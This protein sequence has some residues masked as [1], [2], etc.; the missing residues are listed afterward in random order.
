MSQREIAEG[1]IAKAST[2]DPDTRKAEYLEAL[3]KAQE[4]DNYFAEPYMLL[5]FFYFKEQNWNE[6]I[7]N[8]TKCLDIDYRLSG[9]EEKAKKIYLTLGKSH[10]TVGNKEQSLQC[11]KNFIAHFPES[12]LTEK[13][14]K[15]IFVKLKD[16]EAWYESYKKGYRAFQE[17]KYKDAEHLFTEAITLNPSFFWAYYYHGMA[18]MSLSM[19]PESLNLAL[20]DL[21]KAYDMN[22]H[23]LI[24]LQLYRV[25]NELGNEDKAMF[26]IEETLE[27]NP[28]YAPAYLEMGK[29]L[30]EKN[31]VVS[32]RENL[33]IARAI[34]PR[35]EIAKE[36]KKLLEAP[37]KLP[38]PPPMPTI[39]SPAVEAKPLPPQEAPPPVEEEAAEPQATSASVGLPE[40]EA[41]GDDDDQVEDARQKAELILDKAKTRAQGFLDKTKE[42]LK[43]LRESVDKERQIAR[44]DKKKLADE[45]EEIVKNAQQQADEIEAKAKQVAQDIVE[46]ARTQAREESA[47]MLKDAEKQL[48][49]KEEERS[50]RESQ[51]R[52]EEAE[53]TNIV[54]KAQEI[55]E[56]ALREAEAE[57]LRLK[58]E[59]EEAAQLVRAEAEKAALKAKKEADTYYVRAREQAD[60]YSDT[61]K[62]EAEEYASRSRDAVDLEIQA[63]REKAEGEAQAI[64]QASEERVQRAEETLKNLE[65]SSASIIAKAKEEAR[66]I[67]KKAR[68][69]ALF[70]AKKEEERI[71][72]EITAKAQAE[73]DRIVDESKD[74]AN[75]ER[76][77]ITKAI[78]QELEKEFADKKREADRVL[79]E[80]TLRAQAEAEKIIEDAKAQA[81]IKYRNIL[82]IAEDEAEQIRFRSLDEA[83]NEKNRL[84]RDIEQKVDE[85]Q[86]KAEVIS[87]DIIVRSEN[88]AEEIINK[89]LADARANYDSTMGNAA[90]EAEKI[91]EKAREFAEKTRT[92]AEDFQKRIRDEIEE[93]RER[94]LEKARQDGDEILKTLCH[95]AD[96][97]KDEIIRQGE[98]EK[99]RI[100]EHTKDE[101]E[102]LRHEIHSRAEVES[103]KIIEE[104]RK[105]AQAEREEIV[106]KA[107]EE[108]ALISEKAREDANR[109]LEETKKAAARDMELIYSRLIVKSQE[110]YGLLFS[111][112]DQEVLNIRNILMQ[113]VS[114][115]FDIVGG[116]IADSKD[117]T[118]KSLE[119]EIHQ[120]REKTEKEVLG[121]GIDM[122]LG[123]L[124]RQSADDVQNGDEEL[125]TR[126]EAVRAVDLDSPEA[127]VSHTKEI[128]TAPAPVPK[129]VTAP[130]ATQQISS[131]PEAL[132]AARDEEIKESVLSKIEE[133][134]DEL[135]ESYG[136]ATTTAVDE[137]LIIS[138]ELL[139]E[140]TSSHEFLPQAIEEDA[141]VPDTLAE[142]QQEDAPWPEETT[143][144][145]E[146][147]GQEA[148]HGYPEHFQEA[149]QSPF[150]EGYAEQIPVQEEFPA[151]FGEAGEQ[152]H[153]PGGLTEEA[154]TFGAFP[155]DEEINLGDIPGPE[156]AEQPEPAE[157]PLQDL[158]AAVDEHPATVA[159]AEETQVAQ[160]EEEE[161]DAGGQKSFGT[162]LSQFFDR[163]SDDNE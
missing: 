66:I 36:A 55:A 136:E 85:E 96:E 127:V 10:L 142:I 151:G 29:F 148:P 31:E 5:G 87:R 45:A 23:Y 68:S 143:A 62:Q 49:R 115:K 110:I 116:D 152:Q 119:A 158:H 124:L 38:E 80:A 135:L 32:A 26:I 126:L 146:G 88:E 90:A 133:I 100:L 106:R 33:E 138:D 154:Q 157:L 14:I 150:E 78:R 137:N 111:K 140:E 153:A 99:K 81:E 79:D 160:A 109:L 162:F 63:L 84:L 11:Y 108:K 94:I 65:T 130:V 147:Y 86:K 69:E 7:A 75:K 107:G 30:L 105:A 93:E 4:A 59:A 41:A 163:G 9:D 144:Q 12:A 48:S 53:A 145:E 18:L 57:V 72:H 77:R 83:E 42:E 52:E 121:E 61:T 155:A 149:Y 123:R 46:Q 97:K 35:G 2:L 70:E 8:L 56:E 132:K 50:E 16:V 95:E 51:E 114:E 159:H 40:M 98:D 34:E 112:A 118:I 89:A 15:Q 67:I 101:A 129:S 24:G 104:V 6:T 21:Q 125:E 25:I 103:V 60:A 117:S 73:A 91:Q 27:R 139:Q 131:P 122:I 28:L 43:V 161:Q 134:S 20:A 39:V 76:D 3:K 92:E 22:N 44:D 17:K 13:L 71:V 128:V 58:T 47:R 64:V 141:L 113:A 156:Y 54:E 19:E 1:L 120:T 37:R 74:L 102:V 82:G